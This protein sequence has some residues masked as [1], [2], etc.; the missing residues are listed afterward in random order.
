MGVLDIFQS[1]PTTPVVSSILP[2]IAK[3]E[4]CSGRL[5]ILKTNKIFLKANEEC[6]YIEKAVYEK[7][8]IHKTYKRKSTG[9]SAP[10]IFKGTRVHVGGG[11]TD[12][13]EKA[14]YHLINGLLFITNKRIIFVGQSEGFDK[15]VNSL[16]AVTPYRNCIEFQFSKENIKVFVPDGNITNAVLQQLR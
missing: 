12:V 13:S 3:Q 2:E 5:P 4:I 9:Y 14:E 8:T 16:V 11:N 15:T 6:H 10:G 7:K 1:K